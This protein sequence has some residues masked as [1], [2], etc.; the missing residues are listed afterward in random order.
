M[1]KG[2]TCFFR[3]INFGKSTNIGQ[4]MH[5]ARPVF[6]L[7]LCLSL[8]LFFPNSNAT[9]FGQTHRID[10]YPSGGKM[11]EGMELNGKPQGKW[12]FYH[13]N[14][15][16]KS[17]IDYQKKT[18]VHFNELGNITAKG[19]LSDGGGSGTWKTWHSNGK[20][21]QQ[22]RY[23]SGLPHGTWKSWYINGQTASVQ[24]FLKGKRTGTWL[25]YSR[26]GKTTFKGSF[27][28]DKPIGIWTY[29]WDGANPK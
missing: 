10:R 8:Q 5:S 20:P 28:D 19:T 25:N 14:G 11:A 26:T 9:L 23:I 29:F 12:T 2:G 27:K 15:S 21:E 24:F 13:P 18:A 3:D 1:R 7:F 17:N 22:K 16:I 4:T 6:F